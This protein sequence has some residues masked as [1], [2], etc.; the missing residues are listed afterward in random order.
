MVSYP[1]NYIQFAFTAPVVFFFVFLYLL[2]NI[3]TKESDKAEK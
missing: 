1:S 2:M 3:D